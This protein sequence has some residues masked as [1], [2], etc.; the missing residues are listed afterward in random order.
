MNYNNEKFALLESGIVEPLYYDLKGEIV[1]DSGNSRLFKTIENGNWYL[2]Y[3]GFV[4]NHWCE[5]KSKIIRFGNSI[6]ELLKLGG[7]QK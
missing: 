4:G 1:R 3:H 2:F 5:V 7:A 6:E